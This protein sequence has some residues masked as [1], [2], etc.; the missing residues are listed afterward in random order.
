[1][2]QEVYQIRG[3]YPAGSTLSSRGKLRSPG[4]WEFV[5]DVASGKV[6]DRYVFKSMRH[7]LSP[8]GR[9]PI[10]YVNVE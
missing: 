1:M 9:N 8:K 7:Y 5:G 10:R 4:R 2:V 3:W 6:R